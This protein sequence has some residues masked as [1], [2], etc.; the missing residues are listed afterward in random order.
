MLKEGTYSAWFR[1]PQGQG[2]GI[3]HLAGGKVSGCDTV[4]SYTGRYEA[5]GDRFTAVITTRRHAPGHPS[6]FGV[7]D[8]TLNLEGACRGVT[9]RCWGFA[10]EAPELPFEATLLHSVS[11]DIAPSPPLRPVP[12]FVPDR[13]PK[14]ISR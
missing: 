5:N 14:P 6:V 9:F 10:A 1:T 7:D 8:L 2:T 11:D 13:L 12:K 4:L 3:V